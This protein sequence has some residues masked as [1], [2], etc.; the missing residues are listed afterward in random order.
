MM[1]L[2]I[3]NHFKLEKNKKR[4]S[5]QTNKKTSSSLTSLRYQE[6][7]TVTV[8][9]DGPTKAN[10]RPHGDMARE[11]GMKRVPL[12]TVLGRTRVTR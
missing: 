1:H 10:L 5:K 7:T 3:L 6:S 11:S 2:T 4:N 9:S 12:A 8:K